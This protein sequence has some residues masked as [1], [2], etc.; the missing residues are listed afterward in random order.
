M[1]ASNV[2]EDREKLYAISPKSIRHLLNAVIDEVV[3]SISYSSRGLL[4]CRLC[5]SGPYTPK[6]MYLHLKRKHL[7]E[8][9]HLAMEAIYRKAESIEKEI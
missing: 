3:E 6:G 4:Q 7:R 2:G 1:E 9:K 8:I 5:M